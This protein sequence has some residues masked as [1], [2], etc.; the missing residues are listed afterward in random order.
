MLGSMSSDLSFNVF[1]YYVFISQNSVTFCFK[2][3]VTF[4][5]FVFADISKLVLS[6]I[7]LH[8]TGIIALNS[9]QII[10]VWGA[11]GSGSAS[12]S[13]SR[14]VLTCHYLSPVDWQLGLSAACCPSISINICRDSLRPKMEGF[15][16]GRAVLFPSG[17]WEYYHPEPFKLDSWLQYP[18]YFIDINLNYKSPQGSEHRFSPPWFPRLTGNQLTKA[19]S[20]LAQEKPTDWTWGWREGSCVCVALVPE[21]LSWS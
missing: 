10:P 13:A 15:P 3:C 4:Y 12:G 5:S 8:V 7:S 16:L 1:I 21:S 6:F 9:R 2:F 11:G 14:R 20:L 19:F 17:T 18:D